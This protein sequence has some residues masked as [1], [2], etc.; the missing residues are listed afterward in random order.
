M[1]RARVARRLREADD[2]L[3]PE[4]GYG[5]V[6]VDT[7]LVHYQPGEAFDCPVGISGDEEPPRFWSLLSDSLADLTA[8]PALGVPKPSNAEECRRRNR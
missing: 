5:A 4:H 6:A 8:F 3:A 7:F 2:L 1:A